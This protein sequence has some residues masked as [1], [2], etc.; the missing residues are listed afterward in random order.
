[1]FLKRNIQSGSKQIRWFVDNCTKVRQKILFKNN[2]SQLYKE[3]GG[4][5]NFRP[6]QAPNAG[7]VTRFWNSTWLV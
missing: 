2:Q 7:K 6:I 3:F 4:K 1:M 5:A